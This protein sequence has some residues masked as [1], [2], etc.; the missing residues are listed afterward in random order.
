MAFVNK[1]C[2]EIK[3]ACKGQGKAIMRVIFVVRV[4]VKAAF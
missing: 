1:A 3:T 2:C 4:I